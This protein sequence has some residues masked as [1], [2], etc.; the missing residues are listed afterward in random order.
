MVGMQ[1][2]ARGEPHA[3]HRTAFDQQVDHAL[4]EADL[5]AQRLDLGSH[6]LDH[7]DQPEGADV[8]LADVQDLFGRTGLDELGQHLARQV[9]R[10]GDLAPQLAVRKRAGAT[11]AEL[12]VGLGVQHTA[13]PQAPGVLRALAHRLAALE[14]DRRQAHLGQDQGC[15]QAAGA[16]TDDQGAQAPGAIEARWRVGSES[17]ARVG[18]RPHMGVRRQAGEHRG[19]ACNF[20]V[21]GVD[22]LDR[23]LLA[24]V[25]GA[26][27][28]G[29]LR[30][31]GVPHAEPRHDGR[32]QCALGMAERQ[33]QFGQTQHALRSRKAG[34]SRPF[35]GA[36]RG[37]S[38]C[39]CASR[40][41]G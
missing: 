1:F 31:I 7:A 9:P 2:L 33:A 13:A 41:P 23:R 25:V 26:P 17:V 12:H 18:R 3:T 16:E 21:D 20:A 8:R 35:S 4:L 38:C 5:A 40:A 32:P 6:L 15:E 27:E 24:R 10:I 11:L 19:F 39:A 37:S 36:C 22:Q 14:H 29:E 30:Q 34:L 28:D